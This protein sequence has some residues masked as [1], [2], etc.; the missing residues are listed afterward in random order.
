MTPGNLTSLVTHMPSCNALSWAEDILGERQ[1]G[2]KW[3]YL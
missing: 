1:E 2:S 3:Q